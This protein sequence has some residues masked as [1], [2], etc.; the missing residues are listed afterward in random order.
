[1]TARKEVIWVVNQYASTPDTGMGGRHF[2]LARELV[3]Q[4][5]V[6][7]VI[8]SSYNHL[9]REPPRVTGHY[10]E[11]VVDGVHYIWLKMPIYSDAHSKKRIF[12]WFL[13]GWK[14]LGLNKIIKERPAAILFSS[15]SLVAYLGAK[16]LANRFA[17]KLAFE[18]RDIWPLTF[19]KIGGFSK[20]H[21]FILFMQL[22]ERYAYSSADVVLSN[23]RNSVEHM[24]SLE[25]DPKKFSWIPNGISLSEVEYPESLPASVMTKLPRNKFIVGYTGT[26]GV[27]NAMEFYIDA[28]EL[29][30]KYSDICFVLVGDGKERPSLERLV[31]LKNLNNVVFI[32]P[33]QKK[34]VQSLLSHFDL[35]YIGWRDEDIYK[36]GIAPNKLPEYMAATKPIVHSFSGGGD[37]VSESGC[38]LTVPAE[39]SE[40]IAAAIETLYLMTNDE[41]LEMGRKGYEFASNNLNYSKLAHKLAQALLSE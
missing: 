35:C 19:I 17:C 18:V 24:S 1:M 37:Y 4:G 31:I 36:Y 30:K 9:L 20:K 26:L 15:P 32:D 29:V 28:A 33:V 14:L 7:Y 11:E 41:R 34:Q 2:Y 6:V 38:G 8:G 3:K 16:V 22:I 23:L 21:P 25:M 27:A 39:D 40:S 13:F 5:Y 12:N 10:L